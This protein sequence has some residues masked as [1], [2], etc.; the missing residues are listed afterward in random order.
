MIDVRAIA[1]VWRKAAYD[2]G[3]PQHALRRS[4][5]LE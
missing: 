4:A 5:L 1:L 2:A 3:A